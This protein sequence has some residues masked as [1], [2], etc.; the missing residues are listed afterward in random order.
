M[1]DKSE[2]VPPGRR[3]KIKNRGPLK[4]K[5]KIEI[6]YK[7]LIANELQKDVAKEYRISPKIVCVLIRKVQKD[8]KLLDEL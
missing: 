4:V 6:V 1:E 5:D 3:R 7:V 8:H 2:S